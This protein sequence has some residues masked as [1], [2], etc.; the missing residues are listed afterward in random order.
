MMAE[1]AGRLLRSIRTSTCLMIREP[2]LSL[3][4]MTM[5]LSPSSIQFR[6]RGKTWCK[7]DFDGSIRPGA[8][9]SD[10]EST[11]QNFLLFACFGTKFDGFQLDLPNFFDRKCELDESNVD[12]SDFE[13][14]YI[15]L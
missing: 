8:L 7:Y 10:P 2:L 1:S 12:R 5:F 3:P 11:F 4:G 14:W 15:C 6:S 13:K 9:I